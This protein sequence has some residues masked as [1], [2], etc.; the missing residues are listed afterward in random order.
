[1]D[2]L[3]SVRSERVIIIIIIIIIH[4]IKCDASYMARIN[5]SINKHCVE[6]IKYVTL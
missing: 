5:Y 6:M 2:A 3:C 4:I 1:V